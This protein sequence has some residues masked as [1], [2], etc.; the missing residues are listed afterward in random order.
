MQVPIERKDTSSSSDEDNHVNESPIMSPTKKMPR[1]PPNHTFIRIQTKPP[2][3][4]PPPLPSTTTTTDE[5]PRN[6]PLLTANTLFV[7]DADADRALGHNLMDTN[8]RKH[9]VIANRSDLFRY[10]AD[11][12][13]KEWLIHK[14]V[15][16]PSNKHMPLLLLV[17]DD[18]LR[19]A[20]GAEYQKRGNLQ[21][22]QLNGFKLPEFILH[23]MRVIAQG[24]RIVKTSNHSLIKT[25]IT[26]TIT[27]AITTIVP[28]V[29]T[30]MVTV[31]AATSATA[32]SN[33]NNH[34]RMDNNMVSMDGNIRYTIHSQFY[35]LILF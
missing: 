19:I 12:V 32:T 18:I 17:M 21:L 3:P 28:S 31:K 25:A 8:A 11:N 34:H 5:K 15:L 1:I 29:T 9:L 2:P 22:Y 27:S 4:P 6:E 33:N 13:D 14:R 10:P 26:S 30:T 24:T 16:S 20:K 35:K 23:K 7:C